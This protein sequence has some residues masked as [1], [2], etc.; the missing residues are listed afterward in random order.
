VACRRGA[1]A[2]PNASQSQLARSS[3][4]ESD[5]EPVALF[6]AD[7]GVLFD[8]SNSITSDADP[9]FPASALALFGRPMVKG[10]RWQFHK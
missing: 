3:D 9:W 2:G 6:P 7:V 10:T 1:I 8:N 5:G 4:L